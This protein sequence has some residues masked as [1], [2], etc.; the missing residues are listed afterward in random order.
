MLTDT[1]DD[2]VMRIAQATLPPDI[3]VLD[4]T[5]RDGGLMSDHHFND[6][7]V[8]AVHDACSAAGVD[9]VEI[10]YRA[11]KRL[12]APDQ[13]GVWK[14]CAEDDIRRALGDRPAGAK[15]S[16]MADAGRTDY[17]EDIP[18]AERSAVSLVRV[19]CYAD[20]AKLAVDMVRDA[21]DKGYET[22]VNLMAISRLSIAELDAALD[23]LLD[24]PA[25][26]VYVLDSYGAFHPWQIGALTGRYAALAQKAGKRV[27]IH[28]H[29]NLQLAYANTLEALTSGAT[30]ADATIAGI[31]RGAGNCPLEALIGFL[32]TLRAPGF[33]RWSLRPVLSCISAQMEVLC[34]MTSWPEAL[35]YMLTG[36]RNEHPRAAIDFCGHRGPE[37]LLG[38]FDSLSSEGPVSP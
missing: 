5:L 35:P 33:S 27:G 7:F 24:T 26:T 8:R 18:P 36:L 19:A 14:Y 21:H 4:C 37:D 9:Y 1:G 23:L 32:V 29:N 6:A 31:G 10:G 15:L 16:V 3:R 12:Y 34:A 30:W 2:S 25:G 38:F 17:H 13:F 11:S 22:S 28:T 20:Q